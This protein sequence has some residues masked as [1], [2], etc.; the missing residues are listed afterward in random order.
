[1]KLL[2]QPD[3]GLPPLITAIK[4]AQ[5]S[6]DLVIFRADV[7][8]FQKALETTVE[9]GVAVH[10]LIAHTNR[11]GEKRLRKLEQALLKAGVT[12]SRTGDDLIRYHGKMMVIDKH[13]LYTLGFNYTYLDILKSR[14]FGIVTRNKA[15][16]QEALRLFEADTTRQPFVPEL[17]TFVVSPENSRARLAAFIKRARKQLLIYDPKIADGPMIRLLNERASAGVEIRVLGRITSRREELLVEKLPKL[18]LHIRAILRDEQYLF[19]G[20]QSLRPMELDRRREIGVIVREPKVI[21]QFRTVFE[22]DWA[23]TDIAAKQQRDAKKEDSKKEEAKEDEKGEAKHEEV[24]AS[25]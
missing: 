17:D 3:H 23:L 6:V 13:T 14:S 25:K 22:A 24:L 15:F 5:T 9:R 16:V 10:A 18:R 4:Q 20:S 11:G 12:V 2:V 19:M 8:E 7:K 1:M 21:K